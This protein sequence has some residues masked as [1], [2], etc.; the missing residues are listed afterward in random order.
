MQTLGRPAGGRGA[1]NHSHFRLL[2]SPPTAPAF[3]P[4]QSRRRRRTRKEHRSR[5]C[6]SL[7]D[8]GDLARPPPSRGRRPLPVLWGVGARFGMEG[9]RALLSPAR[10][11]SW[12]SPGMLKLKCKSGGGGGGA[13]GRKLQGGRGGAALLPPTI[14]SPLQEALVQVPS[15]SGQGAPNPYPRARDGEAGAT[16]Q[17]GGSGAEWLP[18]VPLPSFRKPPEPSGR[19]AHAR[20]GWRSP[21]NASLPKASALREGSEK[22]SGT[23]RLPLAGP[24]RGRGRGPTAMHLGGGGVGAAADPKSWDRVL[25]PHLGA[26]QGTQTR[27]PHPHPKA[28]KGQSPQTSSLAPGGGLPRAL[29]CL[30]DPCGPSSRPCQ[31]PPQAWAC[32][33]SEEPSWG[34]CSSLGQ[35]GCRR[36]PRRH[37]QSPHLGGAP[38]GG[39][40]A[41]AWGAPGPHGPLLPGHGGQWTGPPSSSVFCSIGSES[42]QTIYRKDPNR[43]KTETPKT[44]QAT[45]KRLRRRAAARAQPC[46]PRRAPRGEGAPAPHPQVNGRDHRAHALTHAHIHTRTCAHLHTR[47]PIRTPPWAVQPRAPESGRKGEES[48]LPS[49]APRPAVRNGVSRGGGGRAGPVGR[50]PGRETDLWGQRPTW[51][52]CNECVCFLHPFKYKQSKI[53]FFSGNSSSQ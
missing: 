31:G 8:P 36:L 16:S 22:D 47:T 50:P 29:S 2:R 7:S 20:P 12:L 21:P 43:N 25:R 17:P 26:S 35:P 38:T 41:Q 28:N 39:A 11:V 9:D 3:P 27:G 5:H 48:G 19:Q 24:A 23:P 10:T 42:F 49:P 4:D 18:V 45:P 1:Q 37:P 51:L 34:G 46:T 44:N 14:L 30:P 53:T 52:Q 15:S 13:D 40:W 32:S 33:Q 6:A